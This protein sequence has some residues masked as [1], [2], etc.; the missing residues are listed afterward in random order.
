[1]L[2]SSIQKAKSGDLTA[3]G[4]LYDASYDRVYRFIF[5][6]TLD[7]T[8]TEDIIQDV[9]SKAL[10]SIS[11]FR[12]QSPGEFFSW[13]LHIAYTT[14]IDHLRYQAPIERFEDLTWEPSYTEEKQKDI[15]T[16][17]T[18]EAVLSYMNTFKERDRLILTMR[19]WEEMSYEEISQITGESVSNA[20]KIVSRSLEKI[21]ANVQHFSIISFLV[22][23]V[24]VR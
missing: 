15:D 10:K 19:I 13:V 6:R 7:T 3:F 23:Y 5:Y 8:F 24:F 9:Y 20:K 17:D 18:L 16:K 14:L 12:G 11:K 22:S 21:S 4:E 1:M 2:E